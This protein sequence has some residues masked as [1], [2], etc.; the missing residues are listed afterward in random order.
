ML[1]ISKM[2]LVLA[3]ATQSLVQGQV[4]DVTG[5]W[6]LIRPAGVTPSASPLAAWLRALPGTVFT[7]TPSTIPPLAMVHRGL[8]Y[9]YFPS[10][11]TITVLEGSPDKPR[12]WVSCNRKSG[13]DLK[14]NWR[15]Q[16][17]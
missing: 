10:R 5:E 13:G 12:H 4:A 16:S 8:G 15:L 3:F 14:A 7:L 9:T 2:V 11:P 1:L 6:S 17:A